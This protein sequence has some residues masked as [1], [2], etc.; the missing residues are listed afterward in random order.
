MAR[1]FSWTLAGSVQLSLICVAG[2]ILALALKP[3]LMSRGV[4]QR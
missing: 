4:A 2:A 3:E 1:E